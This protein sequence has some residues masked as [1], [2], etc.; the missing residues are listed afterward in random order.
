MPSCGS[1]QGRHDDGGRLRDELRATEEALR[2]TLAELDVASERTA[3]ELSAERESDIAAALARAEG[4][5]ERAR[6]L[7]GVL[8]ERGRTVAQALDAAADIDVVSTLEAE[9]ARLS[10]ELI[11]TESDLDGPRARPR[12]AGARGGRG[13]RRSRDPSGRPRWTVRRCVGRS[14][15]LPRP[16][17]S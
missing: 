4:M 3:G 2:A 8:R 14:G 16:V 1:L 9:A 5:V 6:G 11:S 17:A 13:G 10:G 15:P 7:I 12:G